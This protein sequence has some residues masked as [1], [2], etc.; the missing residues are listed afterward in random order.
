MKRFIH[1]CFHLLLCNIVFVQA[2]PV[3]DSLLLLLKES[4]QDTNRVNILNHLGE[5]TERSNPEEKLKYTKEAL[6]LS[7]KLIFLEGMARACLGMSNYYSL[8]GLPDSNEIYLLKSEKIL[9]KTNNQA[10]LAKVYGNMGALHYKLG[11]T[12]KAIT[13]FQ[14]AL[15]IFEKIKDKPNIAKA[16]VQ[17]SLILQ[18]INNYSDAMKHLT[19]AEKINN[20]IGNETGLIEAYLNIG[21]IHKKTLNFDSAL[22]YYNK[23]FIIA[24]KLNDKFYLA[25]LYNNIGNVYL[26]KSEYKAAIAYYDKSIPLRLDLND[27]SG[28]N[29]TYSNLALIYSDLG[30]YEQSINLLKK[31]EEISLREKDKRG[32]M[33]TYKY[34]STAYSGKKDYKSAFEYFEKYSAIRDTLINDQSN[35]LITDLEKKYESEK[36]DK[37]IQLL[38]KTNLLR[39]SEIEKQNIDLKRKK[40]QSYALS[41]GILFMFVLSLVIF[42]SYKRKKKDNELIL[43]QKREVEKQNSII[44]TQKFEVE[45]K[46]KEILDS[47]K[48]AKRL[49]EAILPPKR[50]VKEWL[51]NSFVLYKPKDIVAGDF[52][53]MESLNNRTYFAAADCTGHGVP[54]AMVSVICSN[55]LNKS[56]IEENIYEP[57]KILDRTRELVIERFSRSDEDVKDGMDISLCSINWDSMELSWAGANNPV[58]IIN[59]NRS[60]WP[61]QVTVFIDSKAGAEIKA[62]KQPIGNFLNATPFTNHTFKLESGD[63]VYIFTDGYQDQFGGDKGKKLK[64]SGLKKLLETNYSKSMDEQKEI[65]SETFEKW[66]GSL[67]QIDDV[68]VIGVRI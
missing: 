66:R 40:I 21:I 6:I 7:E 63:T 51:P 14:K 68:C 18:G 65:I 48:Y 58:W 8:L 36:K 12:E 56:L 44:E 54:G 4:K 50:L 27:W 43:K 30:K 42:K 31:C 15:T 38:N 47:I 28:L 10:G 19:D 53:W 61:D 17:I 59:P 23:A 33:H 35:K 20:E 13:Y 62:N 64:A 3:K 67:E 37:E 39:D 52:Y 34:F 5:I 29:I 16:N 49:Q 24:E 60:A 57:A 1:L 25:K 9:L 46:N 22:I 45:E 11:N 26:E 32:L 55:A 41:G 2:N